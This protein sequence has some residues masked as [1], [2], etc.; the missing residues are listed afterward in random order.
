MGKVVDD[1]PLNGTM[2]NSHQERKSNRPMSGGTGRRCNH[3]K[4]VLFIVAC[5]ATR[6][7]CMQA[8]RPQQES[9]A[10]GAHAPTIG[11]VQSAAFVAHGPLIRDR[12]KSSCSYSFGKAG[13]GCM[14][15]P[16][17][18][19]S[20]QRHLIARKVQAREETSESTELVK[21]EKVFR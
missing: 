12:M 3:M 8:L 11:R 4:M 16:S 10:I 15:G 1:V 7:I 17:P 21:P 14:L 18:A 19:Q 5:G 6:A 13:K 9:G 2:G 20:N